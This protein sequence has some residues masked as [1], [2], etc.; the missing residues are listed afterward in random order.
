MKTEVLMPQMGE[1]IAEGTIVTWFKKV[2]DKVE[3]DENL[4]EI[5]TDK[6]D[7]E[8]PAPVSGYLVEILHGP[9]TTVE[10]N[11][12]VAYISDQMTD[13]SS[14]PAAAP[15]PTAEPAK[16]AAPVAIAPVS[17]TAS[18]DDLRKTR[19][20]PLVRK[21]AADHGV[22]ISGLS[23]TGISGRVTKKDFV[24][25][26]ARPAAVEAPKV[27]RPAAA[28]VARSTKFD[29]IPQAADRVEPYSSMRAAIAEHMVV[30]RE[31]SVHVSTVFEVDMTRVV[32]LRAALKSSYAKRGVNLTY[33]PFIIKA[34]TEGLREFPI[35]NS[36]ILNNS[37]YYKQDIN[38][39]IAVAL[40]WGLLVPVVK[41][42]D[43]L[44]LQGLSRG[45]SELAE[46]ARNK[47]LSPD[48]V[49]GG[50]FTITNPGVYG[51]LFGTPIIN[52]PQVAILGVGTI[53]KRPVVTEDD[54]IAI[55]HMQYLVLSFD[56][57]VIDGAT[58]D[59]F[60]ARVKYILQNFP[61]EA[62]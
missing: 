2:G 60:M 34:V 6:V 12:V 43:E 51:S 46:K 40:D 58:A 20:S 13:S 23:G 16:T 9:G 41:H 39:G 25:H 35:L 33:L 11:K 26:L 30:S 31:T 5:S 32:K 38:I 49:Q 14:A 52:Q 59:K 7:A 21:M 44:S 8:I 28:S 47:K 50:T 54:A 55:R 29:Y 24:E 1:S 10:V 27:S 37:V 48:D 36:S 22:D 4:F 18:L 42:A 53:T 62:T 19:S 17:A 56:H 15:A 45:V 3:R 57:R 61:E